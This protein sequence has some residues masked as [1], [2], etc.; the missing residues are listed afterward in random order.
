MKGRLDIHFQSVVKKTRSCS[1][2]FCCLAIFF[3]FK[4]VVLQFLARQELCWVEGEQNCKKK[5]VEFT[6]SGGYCFCETS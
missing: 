3:F 5:K 1:S 4:I 2:R 6:F